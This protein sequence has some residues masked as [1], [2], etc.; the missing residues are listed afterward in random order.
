MK[1]S[2]RPS[3]MSFYHCFYKSFG[4]VNLHL[5]SR[6]NT[7]LP[8]PNNVPELKGVEAPFGKGV[9]IPSQQHRRNPT[10]VALRGT[11]QG[12]SKSLGSS[13][14]PSPVKSA[15]TG[16]KKSLNI[17]RKSKSAGHLNLHKDK[18]EKNKQ[19]SIVNYT[20][21]GLDS[22]SEV[23]LDESGKPVTDVYM[24]Y[25]RPNIFTQNQV[26][27]H[28][29]NQQQP[30]TTEH[31]ANNSPVKNT[32]TRLNSAS[33]RDVPAFVRD[34]AS[35]MLRQTAS[36]G[37][38][39]LKQKK[40]R[41]KS[42]TD[43]KSCDQDRY[44]IGSEQSIPDLMEFDFQSIYKKDGL[45]FDE[46]W[47]ERMLERYQLMKLQREQ[48]QFAAANKRIMLQNERQ[49]KILSQRPELLYH[50]TCAWYEDHAVMSDYILQSHLFTGA[51]DGSAVELVAK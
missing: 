9:S 42:T 50:D 41:P 28:K 12:V 48:R 4:K 43:S 18:G 47:Q 38:C 10:A 49:Y 17:K 29:L 2:E 21:T 14:K 39:A 24:K 23:T 13:S 16:R 6:G 7:Y 40:T 30:S 3:A 8:I 31:T 34:F 25:K 32:E 36:T 46:S 27:K 37:D 26:P 11:S 35:Q 15:A 45:Q 5:L 1:G 19:E 51:K 20:T 44:E 33:K 22:A